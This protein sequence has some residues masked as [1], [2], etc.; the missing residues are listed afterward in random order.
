MKLI[1][2]WHYLA[3][4]LVHVADT[5]KTI[6]TRLSCPVLSVSA[7]WTELATSKDRQRHK[8]SKL[9]CPVSKCCEDNCKQ[10]WLV[11]NSVHT[12]TD[13]T[14]Q[15]CLY[16]VLSVSAV[17]TRPQCARMHKFMQAAFLQ[18]V[19]NVFTKKTTLYLD[20]SLMLPSFTSINLY[21]HF[22]RLTLYFVNIILTFSESCRL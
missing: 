15:S 7:V 17:W 11:A 13:K 8:I 4:C 19:W 3:W 20:R 18:M 12:G 10:S 21:S 1:F 22:T 5:D 9:F 2:I 16:V 6:Q 14:R